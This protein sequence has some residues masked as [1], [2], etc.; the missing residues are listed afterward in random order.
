MCLAHSACGFPS[1]SSVTMKN[2]PIKAT[3][4]ANQE[5]LRT[6]EASCTIKREYCMCRRKFLKACC[7]K[8]T[9]AYDITTMRKL[10]YTRETSWINILHVCRNLTNISTQFR[11]L[12]WGFSNLGQEFLPITLQPLGVSGRVPGTYS[13]E[14]E[15]PG[16]FVWTDLNLEIKKGSVGLTR[17]EREKTSTISFPIIGK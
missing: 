1:D 9:R 16:K 6:S 15:P 7:S 3:R 8:I 4:N 12:L 13:R 11:M 10:N 5:I 2:N 14:E 17:P